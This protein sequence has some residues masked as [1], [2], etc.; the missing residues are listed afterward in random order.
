MVNLHKGN[1]YINFSIVFSNNVSDGHIEN[2]L[3]VT[4]LLNEIHLK[5]LPF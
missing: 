5:H 4:K 1:K 3:L 2:K